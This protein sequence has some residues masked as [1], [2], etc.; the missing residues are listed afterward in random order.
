MKRSNLVRL[1]AVLAIAAAATG[2]AAVKPALLCTQAEYQSIQDEN[3]R[4]VQSQK[5]IQGYV[6]GNPI[7][8]E[9]HSLA[10][11][12]DLKNAYVR[13]YNIALDA[14]QARSTEFNA[15]CA[16]KPAYWAKKD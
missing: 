5:V 4:L 1:A 2:C 16:G 14:L 12:E 10:T 9:I 7:P 3:A 8:G 6:N 11:R 13:G 15:V